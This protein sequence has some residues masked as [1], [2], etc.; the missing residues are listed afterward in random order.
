MANKYL[1]LS[2]G[3]T[4]E[5]EALVSSAGAGDSGKIPALDTDGRLNISV[6]PSGFGSDA[7]TITNASNEALTDGDFVYIDDTTGACAK[8][9]DATTT[10][11]EAIGY[12]KATTLAG[13]PAIV[14]FG[15]VASGQTVTI[16][17][18]YYLG[19]SAGAETSTPPS[20]TG[21]VVQFLGMAISTTE[22]A[23]EPGEAI[24]VA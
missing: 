13:D 3:R 16:G 11:K 22:I 1:A 15:G 7:V 19:T 24:T 12:V 17:T 10:A 9:A 20:A 2:S 18:R 5:T 8:K 21:N 6:M 14:Y 23:F 4:A